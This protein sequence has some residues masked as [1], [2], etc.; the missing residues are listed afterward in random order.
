MERKVVGVLLAVG[1]TLLV[2][3]KPTTNY[4]NIVEVF[5]GDTFVVQMSGKRET[6][7][8][9]GV[10]TPETK[11]PRKPVQCYGPEASMYSHTKLEHAKVRLVSDPL[12][13]NRDRYNRLLRYAYLQDGTFFNKALL[14]TGN[15]RAYTGFMFSKSSDFS[16]AEQAA[17][18]TM[19]GLWASCKDISKL[20]D[21]A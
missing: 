9:I 12:S 14:Q 4:Y 2:L 10:D 3:C 17:K 8:L 5:D 20:S 15:A 1:L 16:A 11:D 13:T 18:N 6:V 7:R 21:G 19:Q